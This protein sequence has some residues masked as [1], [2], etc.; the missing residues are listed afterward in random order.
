MINQLP[1]T[2][3]PVISS[4]ETNSYLESLKLVRVETDQSNYDSRK[5]LVCVLSEDMATKI[6][7]NHLNARANLALLPEHD[8]IDFFGNFGINYTGLAHYFAIPVYDRRIVHIGTS[9]HKINAARTIRPGHL[10]LASQEEA[11]RYF[12]LDKKYLEA[13]VVPVRKPGHRR[14]TAIFSPKIPNPNNG[15]FR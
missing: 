14:L 6:K 7:P 13:A 2:Q 11:D 8:N 5:L 1:I 4:R 10:F 9:N 12:P 3:T 15:L